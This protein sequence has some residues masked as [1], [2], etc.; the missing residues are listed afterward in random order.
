MVNKDRREPGLADMRV[1]ADHH[2]WI[3]GTPATLGA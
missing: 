1:N 2:S 3:A